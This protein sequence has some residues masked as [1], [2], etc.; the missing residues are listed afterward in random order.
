M[1]TTP[2]LYFDGRAEEA[3]EF[4]RKALGA[5]IGMLMR[6]KDMPPGQPSMGPLPPADKVMHASFKLG[7]TMLFASDGQCGGHPE[8]KGFALSLSAAT[9]AEAERLFAALAKDGQVQ[10]PL[11]ETFFATRFGMVADKFGVAWMVIV[12]RERQQ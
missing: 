4:Y 6:F 5:E 11:N 7:D 3:L 9:D 2:Y 12:E 10:M 8:F 1:Y